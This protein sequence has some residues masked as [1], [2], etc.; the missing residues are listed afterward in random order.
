MISSRAESP[1]RSAGDPSITDSIWS[2]P[3]D[4]RTDTPSHARV[5][6]CPSPAGS[7]AKRSP[8]APRKRFQEMS[9]V[10]STKSAKKRS[11]RR[12][13]ASLQIRRNSGSSSPRPRRRQAS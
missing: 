7:F 11:R 5:F 4:F 8:A 12:P 1:A 13:A 10:P 6:P 2:A 9:V 3:P